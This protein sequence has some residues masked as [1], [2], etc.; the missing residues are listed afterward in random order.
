MS[1]IDQLTNM[2]EACIALQNAVDAV[3]VAELRSVK[4]NKV[5]SLFIQG[6][7][8]LLYHKP[9]PHLTDLSILHCCRQP[10]VGKGTFSCSVTASRY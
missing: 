10:T 9:L 7:Q 5:S 6:T 4:P 8:Y 2:Q 1:R 3:L